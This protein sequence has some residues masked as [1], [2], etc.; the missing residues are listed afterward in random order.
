MW[1]WCATRFSRKRNGDNNVH[2]MCV[3]TSLIKMIYKIKTTTT[4]T[5][6]LRKPSKIQENLLPFIIMS[7]SIITQTWPTMYMGSIHSNIMRM[8]ESESK[9]W[10]TWVS[11]K[12]K[13]QQNKRIYQQTA[14]NSMLLS[15]FFYCLYYLE[16]DRLSLNVPFQFIFFCSHHD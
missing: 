5:N 13:E 4:T 11:K 9:W 8:I 14:G 10:M 2:H 12:I 15:S 1:C 6:S 16:P 7:S 3:C